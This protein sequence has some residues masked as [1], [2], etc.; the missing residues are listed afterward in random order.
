MGTVPASEG[1]MGPGIGSEETGEH[2]SGG[3][4]PRLCL[5]G[6]S[7]RREK[8]DLSLSLYF[9]CDFSHLKFKEPKSFM[10]D[11]VVG[12]EREMMMIMACSSEEKKRRAATVTWLRA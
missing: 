10:T 1:D 4:A 12:F 7:S 5:E 6:G 3:G 2:D 11:L 9:F 8:P